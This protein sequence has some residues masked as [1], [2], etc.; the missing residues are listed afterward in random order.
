M[1]TT[2][3]ERMEILRAELAQLEKAEKEDTRTLPQK[4]AD[5]IHESTCRLN[6]TDGCGYGYSD[7]HDPC[8]TKQKYLH[9][10]V[11]LLGH[12]Q[13]NEQL[14]YAIVRIMTA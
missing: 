9:K 4:L 1:P 7:W 11:A 12:V 14:A 6:H 10:A 2:R 13:G 3:K 5:F 8:D